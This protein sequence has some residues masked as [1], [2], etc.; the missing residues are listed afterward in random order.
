M[1]YKAVRVT[2]A[3]YPV[4]QL[5]E[6]GV[7]LFCAMLSA[8]TS[9]DFFF[10]ISYICSVHTN[11]PCMCVVVLF[12]VTFSFFRVLSLHVIGTRQLIHGGMYQ[13]TCIKI[14]KLTN[15]LWKSILGKASGRY[16]FKTW[17]PSKF[18][19]RQLQLTVHVYVLS[20]YVDKTIISDEKTWFC[21]CDHHRNPWICE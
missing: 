17:F 12:S 19:M 9:F 13:Y 3:S 2:L 11:I 21:A 20:L 1:V 18:I 6:Y 7:K 14:S 10:T 8:C 5:I 15:Q 16:P 4:P